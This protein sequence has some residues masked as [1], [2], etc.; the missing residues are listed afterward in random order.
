MYVSFTKKPF[1]NGHIYK[2]CV[3]YKFHC[4][5][6]NIH[7]PFNNN[8]CLKYRTRH[9]LYCTRTDHTIFLCEKVQMVIVV[10]NEHVES[11]VDTR[12]VIKSNQTVF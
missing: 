9:Y 3:M 5:P 10:H 7:K 6:E 2:L 11:N 1:Y 8:Y 4:I 12:I